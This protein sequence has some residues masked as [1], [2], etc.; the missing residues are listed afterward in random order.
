MRSQVLNNQLLLIIQNI[1]PHKE[2]FELTWHYILNFILSKLHTQVNK[3]YES[4]DCDLK[5]K[6]EYHFLCTLRKMFLMF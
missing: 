4:S 3:Q 2:S 5:L 6:I 1:K